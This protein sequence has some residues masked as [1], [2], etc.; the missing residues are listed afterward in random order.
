MEWLLHTIFLLAITSGHML[1]EDR[2]TASAYMLVPVTMAVQYS[3][4]CLLVMITIESQLLLLE[5]VIIHSFP[6]I[7]CGMDSSVMVMRLRAVL[8]PT[9]RGSSR[10]LTR[11][12]LRTLNSVCVVTVHLLLKTLLLSWWNC[13][14]VSYC[15][16]VKT[17]YAYAC[18]HVKIKLP[19]RAF[20]LSW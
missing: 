9:C 12:Q 7:H 1:V 3:L 5:F 15:G 13:L 10:H 6:V 14:S 11:P 20:S 4:H 19:R 16:F 8:T 17:L 18:L 2:K